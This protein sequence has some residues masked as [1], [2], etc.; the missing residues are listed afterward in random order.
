MSLQQQQTRKTALITGCS[1]GGIGHA[2]AL[3]LHRDGYRVFATARRID[4]M[5]ELA[6][7]GIETLILDVTSTDSIAAVLAEV[8]GRTEGRGL[9]YLINNAG[10]PLASPAL[11]I[12]VDAAKV[13]FETNFFGIIRMNSAFQHLLVTARGTIVHVGSVA[14]YM[15]FV[16]GAAY[17]A[18]KAALHAYSNT[19][20]LEVGPLGVNVI[21]VVTGG[22]ASN[23]TSQPSYQIASPP[24][25]YYAKVAQIVIKNKSAAIDAG[26]H[27]DRYADQVVRQIT[28]R[29]AW[30]HLWSRQ[31]RP[32]QIWVGAK[33]ALVWFL[34]FFPVEVFTFPQMYKFK[35]DSL[36]RAQLKA[37]ADLKANKL[38]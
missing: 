36:L 8:T 16:F 15:P 19:L 26:M 27:A 29:G 13:L 4:S 18:S 14:A 1:A 11:D 35:L 23:I 32:A 9:D 24:G 7:T 22:V 28:G 38:E 6:A 21:T 37:D 3:R 20:R 17:N 25:S 30:Y 33:A 10:Q 31:V 12:D 2:L 5:K 34:S